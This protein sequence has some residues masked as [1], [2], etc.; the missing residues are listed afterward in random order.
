MEHRIREVMGETDVAYGQFLERMLMFE[1]QKER[2][3]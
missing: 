1:K 3:L 2:R